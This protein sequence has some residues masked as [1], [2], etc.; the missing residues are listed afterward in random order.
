MSS[1]PVLSKLPST[2]EC[3]IASISLTHISMFSMKLP[4]A[5]PRLDACFALPIDHIAV[6]DGAFL[7]VNAVIRSIV[8]P[9]NNMLSQ[10]L[11]SRL[12]DLMRR[13]AFLKTR[14]WIK[15]K[16]STS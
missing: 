4:P 10:F 16:R 7:T 2:F 15:E 6:A 5:H 14:S 11:S 8:V 13:D 1:I 12:M 9:S 3:S